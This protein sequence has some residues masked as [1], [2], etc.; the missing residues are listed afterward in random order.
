MKSLKWPMAV[1]QLLVR[2]PEKQI[3][4]QKRSEHDFRARERD[5]R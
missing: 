4:N 2:N 5:S 1:W 3:P